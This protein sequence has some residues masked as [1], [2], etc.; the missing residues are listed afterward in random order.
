V[1]H[2]LYLVKDFLAESQ[3]SIQDQVAVAEEQVV[4]GAMAQ[5]TQILAHLVMVA[6]EL[7]Q[8]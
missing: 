2:H 7:Q 1:A 5:Q 8:I 6:L 3:Q 4:M